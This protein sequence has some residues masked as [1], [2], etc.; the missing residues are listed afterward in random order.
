MKK[1]VKALFCLLIIWSATLI[2]VF[3]GGL[4]AGYKSVLYVNDSGDL[5]A[6]GANAAGQLGDGTTIDRPEPIIPDEAGPWSEVSTSLVPFDGGAESVHSL[7][8]KA[9]GTLWAWGDNTRGQLGQGDTENRSNPT[10]VGSGAEWKAVAA[11]SGFSMALKQNGEIWVWGDNSYGQ[12]GSGV[13]ENFSTVPLRL[14][15]KDGDS[16]P[17]TF[18]AIAAGANHALAIHASSATASYGQIYAWGR[19]GEGQLGLGHKN[20]VAGP[21]AV[22]APNPGQ[23]WQVVEAGVHSSFALDAYS[24][25]YAWGQGSFGSLGVGDN[26]G[27]AIQQVSSPTATA[28]SVSSAITYE[29]VAAGADHTIAVVSGGG[30]V[31]GTG[32]KVGLG[33]GDTGGADRYT[34]FTYL[35]FNPPSGAG[36]DAIGAGLDF[37]ILELDTGVVLSTGN[38]DRGQ[39][40]IGTTD[41]ASDFTPTVLGAVDLEIDAITLNT[42]PAGVTAG[43]SISFDLII[44]NNGTGEIAAGTAGDIRLAL[45]LAEV[46]GA[47]GQIE[48][49][50]GSAV[51]LPDAIGPNEAVTLSVTRTL[52]ADLPAG[53]YRLLAEADTA[54]ALDE[55]DET[56]NRFATEPVLPLLSDLRVEFAGAIPSTV[57]AG[58]TLTFDVTF[59]NDGPGAIPAGAGSGF[60]YRVI[61]S[62]FADEAAGTIFEL[63]VDG[64]APD[65]ESP[66]VSGLSSAGSADAEKTRTVTVTVPES[67]TVGED[68]F[69]GLIVDS[70]DVVTEL[71]E[72]N[73]T[74]FTATRS[75]SV[76][77]LSV[78][79]ALDLPDPPA[80]DPATTDVDESLPA[81]L[82]S[83]GD[84]DWFGQADADA[85]GPDADSLSSPQLSAGEFASLTFQSDA[86]RVVTFWRKAE[87]SSSQNRLFFGEN[88]NPIEP[89][90][91]SQ[92]SEIFGTTEWAEVAYVI[93]KDQPVGFFYEQ[94]VDAP[95]DRVLI[96][97]LRV[98][99]AITEPDFV[100]DSIE[101][102]AGDYVLER[103]R[104]TVLVRGQ[105]RGALVD[106]LPEN[107]KIRVWLSR[108]RS[109]GGADDVLLGDLNSFQILDNGARFVYQARFNLPEGL[110]DANYHVL[111][112]VDAENVVDE[113]TLGGGAEPAAFTPEDNNWRVSDAA[114]VNIRRLPD[115]WVTKLGE[116]TEF[117]IDFDAV[118]TEPIF[119]GGPTDLDAYS[120]NASLSEN[121]IFAVFIKEP[122]LDDEDKPIRGEIAIRFDVVNRGLGDQTGQSVDISAYLLEERDSDVAAENLL[123][124]FTEDSGFASKSGRTYELTTNIP[125]DV[126]AG[127]F[128]YVAVVVDETDQV[129]ESDEA[130]NS[131]LSEDKDVFVG[132]VP[133][134]VALNDDVA[135]ASIDGRSWDEGYASSFD[136]GGLPDSPWF[137]QKEVFNNDSTAVRAAA[138]SG[139][140]EVGQSTFMTTD[141]T[142]DDVDFPLFVSF[143][144]KTEA[145]PFDQLRLE[146]RDGDNLPDA[147]SSIPY[148]PVANEDPDIVGNVPGLS[149]VADWRKASFIIQKP[150][151]YRL[152]WTYIE[153][154][155]GTLGTAWVDSFSL[156]SPDLLVDSVEISNISNPGSLDAGD[157]FDLG[158]T[159][160]NNG[161]APVNRALVQIRLVKEQGEVANL[162]WTDASFNDVVLVESF[163][164]DLSSNTFGYSE[165]LTLPDGMT[166]DADFYVAVW[167][168]YLDTVPE[169]DETNNLQY[170]ATQLEIRPQLTIKKALDFDEGS[171]PEDSVIEWLLT[172]DGRW[173]PVDLSGGD[174]VSASGE[175]PTEDAMQAPDLQLNKTAGFEA[176]V[177]GPKLLTFWWRARG[178]G[179]DLTNQPNTLCFKINGQNTTRELDGDGTSLSPG[180]ERLGQTIQLFPAN[181]FEDPDGD[182]GWVREAVFIPAGAQS[183][184]WV[185]DRRNQNEAGEF[186]VEQVQFEDI[187]KPDFAIRSV[188]YNPGLYGLERDRFPLQVQVVNRGTR[189]EGF[190]YN[191]LELNVRLSENQ[192]LGQ[193]DLLVGTLPLADVLDG[194]Q[195]IVFSGDLDLPVNLPASD[196]YLLVEV[197][198]LD[199]SFQE[200]EDLLSNNVFVSNDFDVE[201]VA[202]PRLDTELVG[203]DQDKIY[204]PK[205]SLLLDWNLLNIGLG[206]VPAGSDYT[207]RIELWRFDASET[208]FLVSNADFVREMASITASEFLLGALDRDGDTPD[209]IDY[210]TRLRMPSAPEILADLGVVPAGLEEEDAQVTENLDELEE[211]LFFFVLVRDNELPQS[212]D[213][214][215]RYFPG[216][217]FVMRAVPN[218][219]TLGAETGTFL[220]YDI[221]REQNQSVFDPEGGESGLGF[222]PEVPGEDPEGVG[223]SGAK[224]FIHYALNLPLDSAP[225][226]NLD[227]Q[228]TFTKV[229]TFS[230][231]DGDYRSLTFPVVRGAVDLKYIVEVSN[232]DGETWEEDPLV[233]I[234]PPYLDNRGL[235]RAGYLGAQ[236]LTSS[237]Q[238][239]SLIKPRSMPP[240]PVREIRINQLQVFWIRTIPRW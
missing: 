229:G 141:I 63:P 39:L 100:I 23:S 233:E 129:E 62:E 109:G 24:K 61:L 106:P 12:L 225:G 19:N 142:E 15:D 69:I 190:D 54:D 140:V 1:P 134:E 237:A 94:G 235:F 160:E 70:G 115:L 81:A 32:V 67:A 171:T 29:R 111:A 195:Q 84:A 65:V 77:G 193:D 168:D 204:Y 143:R 189:P 220:T 51:P 159:V 211:H 139:P 85:P 42:D 219:Q 128:Y 161:D 176:I 196:Y 105:N 59:I 173:F 169:K 236:S 58:D 222:V 74:A 166:E 187:D 158:F 125:E 167:V 123:A 80:D 164:A 135:W 108:D 26:F 121:R 188:D 40:G 183:I 197:K 90:N 126:V 165:T 192:T 214:A 212:S 110:E 200:Y 152:R 60:A 201:I 122:L 136:T 43:S 150:G 132:E 103:D 98:G 224:N 221:W 194:G 202:L 218:T 30:A 113:F 31:Y 35:N 92:A 5:T 117:P 4:S 238:S 76:T 104:L 45:G 186:W 180:D 198:S 127:R 86:P 50:E 7:A 124:T 210:L 118:E 21:R 83:G 230:N 52:P 91:R 102:Q 46:F 172:G 36:I 73:N 191:D 17:D 18:I 174:P 170:S 206:D 75:L 44:R 13:S 149:G 182:T 226:I 215:I 48:F 151:D 22:S 25:L 55:S 147:E 114:D 228:N 10:R 20:T 146:I 14:A 38:N 88:R 208:E 53:D 16:T 163:E 112:R 145:G 56:N 177:Q 213:L 234:Q 138:Q 227:A 57:S 11:G 157:S 97:H 240:I 3:G 184:S 8:I 155:D 203:F 28:N 232:D 33:A 37:S 209:Q 175:D 162:D 34:E 96:D 116:N 199:P 205:E 107:L 64:D 47:D 6:W 41:G 78:R 66:F 71:S 101:Y 231:S 49:T 72:T 27:T 93:P 130:N 148:R 178:E 144:W 120:P 207:Q 89:E 137:G 99:P 131:S 68:F 153:D 179:P 133:L 154:D 79:E 223:A 9:D 216:Q 185:Y 87:T 217:R 2:P 239:N 181:L 119:V 95:A 156:E 82:T